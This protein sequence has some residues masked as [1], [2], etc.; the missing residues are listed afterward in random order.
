MFF[1][2]LQ[3]D[4]AP[5]LSA[6]SLRATGVIA[7]TGVLFLVLQ[8]VGALA[9]SSDNIIIAQVLGAE[10]VAI[11]AVPE[12]LFSLISTIIGMALAPL[13]PAYGEAIA[14]GDHD[15]VNSIFKRSLRLAI[16]ISTACSIL[17]IITGPWI[18]AG[19]VHNMVTPSLLLLV[20]FGLWKVLEFCGKCTR[21]LSQWRENNSIPSDR[22]DYDSYIG[23]NVENTICL[24]DWFTRSR[25]GN[26]LL[27][28]NFHYPASVLLHT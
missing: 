10:A 23:N 28:H 24:T 16:G 26:N 13:W 20:G 25:M 3:R 15:W 14:R 7:K 11:Y 21:C 18:I 27:V 19:W 4:I 9:Y 1:L 22:F 5:V 12:K 8:V 17:L 2:V 6:I